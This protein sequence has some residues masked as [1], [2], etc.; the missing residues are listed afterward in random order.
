MRPYLID[1]RAYPSDSSVMLNSHKPTILKMTVAVGF[2]AALVLAP[3]GVLQAQAHEHEK[4]AAETS[5][6]KTVTGEVVDLMCYVDHNATGDKH[7]SCAAKC[8]KSGGPVGIASEGKT[9]LIV[10]DH[11]PMNEQLADYAGKTITVKGKV[12]ERGGL[13]MIENAEIVKK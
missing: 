4:D 13:T 11:K 9:Y 2:T 5:A 3:L 1:R 10:G 7:A 12:A 6:E 8:I